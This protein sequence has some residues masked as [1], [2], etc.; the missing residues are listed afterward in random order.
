MK[1]RFLIIPTLLALL[2]A[3]DS[4]ENV[5]CKD[6][7]CDSEF[8][9]IT[10]YP[11]EIMFSI[12]QFN[13]TSQTSQ[14]VSGC[15]EYALDGNGS[16]LYVM[17]DCR[18]YVSAPKGAYP[19]TYWIEIYTG[20]LPETDCLTI[21]E[22][23]MVGRFD[24]KCRYFQTVD[25]AAYYGSQ[26][27]SVSGSQGLMGAL[28]KT[29]PTLRESGNYISDG[30]GW[31][32]CRS[33][34]CQPTGENICFQDI[35]TN[36]SKWRQYMFDHGIPLDSDLRGLLVVNNYEGFIEGVDI[37]FELLPEG[38]EPYAIEHSDCSSYIEEE[39][40]GGFPRKTIVFPQE[41]QAWLKEARA[42]FLEQNRQGTLAYFIDGIP[43]KDA[44]GQKYTLYVRPTIPGLEDEIGRLP[45]PSLCAD[46]DREYI[47]IIQ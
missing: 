43:V 44:A 9:P 7:E 21:Q 24:N 2:L 25:Y 23:M 33:A 42:D 8:T 39:G 26:K 45:M 12:T 13:A 18:Y 36:A 10:F 37:N 47:N 4:S 22:E 11:D 46:E 5:E 40:F 14:I 28:H 16:F 20:T 34:E 1:R 35:F 15:D 3:C 29:S 31:V 6:M 17:G 27:S 19:R 38:L 30:H 41:Y 32:S